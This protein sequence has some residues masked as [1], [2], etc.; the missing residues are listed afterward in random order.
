MNDAV[1]NDNKRALIVLG[2]P[3]LAG[4]DRSAT[5]GNLSDYFEDE[6]KTPNDGKF[7]IQAESSTFN[8]KVKV[9]STSP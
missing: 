5:G 4:Q 7:E 2:G 6:N 1:P 3:A 9:L 8:D